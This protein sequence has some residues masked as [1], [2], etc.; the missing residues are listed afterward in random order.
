[1]K[2]AA[3]L[4]PSHQPS[5]LNCDANGRF[6]TSPLCG[7]GEVSIAQRGPQLLGNP[8]VPAIGTVLAISKS[9]LG[10]AAYLPRSTGRGGA[11][12]RSSRE[13]HALRPAQIAN[14]LAA[15][16]HAKAI[17]LPFTRMVTIHWGAAG[18]PLRGIV[19]ATG[20]FTDLMTKALA[21][22]GSR[23]AWLWVLENGHGKGGHCHMLAHVPAHLVPRLTALHRGWLR[24]ITGKPYQRRVIR[25]KP[26]GG[27]LGLERGTP[28]FTRAIWR[29]RSSTS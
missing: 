4:A 21:R 20:R 3:T 11:R 18:V 29:L 23:T 16:K 9:S 15:K 24:I 27:R 12:N 8:P 28:T 13:S 25:S 2:G 7:F 19:K 6:E 22:H 1:M 17:G 5:A 26:I 14:L 10:V